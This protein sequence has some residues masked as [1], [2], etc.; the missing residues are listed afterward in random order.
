MEDATQHENVYSMRTDVS[1]GFY[2]DLIEEYNT[3]DSDPKYTTPDFLVDKCN[4]VRAVAVDAHG[5]KSEVVTASYFVGIAPEDYDGCGIVSVVTDPDNLFGYEDGIYVTGKTFDRYLESGIDLDSSYWRFWKANYRQTGSEWERTCSVTFFAPDGGL[6]QEQHIGAVRTHGGV[7][8]GTVPRSLNLY[9]RDTSDTEGC[10]EA[11]LFD[12][13]YSPDAVTLASGGNR[14]YTKFN[15]YMIF[16]RCSGLGYSNIKQKPYILFLDGE[17]WGFYWLSE[18]YDAGYLAY[19]YGVDPD[20][21]VMIKNG[22]VECGDVTYKALYLNMKRWITDYDLADSDN[23]KKACE[24]I[25]IDS[26]IDY[27]AT[28][29]YIA[30]QEDW[31]SS[32]F[33]LWRTVGDDGGGYSDGKWRWMMFDCNSTSMNSQ[34]LYDDSLGYIISNDELFASFWE[35]DVFRDAFKARLMGIADECFDS[36]EMERFIDGYDEAMRKILEKSWTRFHGTEN[37]IAQ[38]YESEMDGY[39]TFF[40]ERKAVVE[41]WFN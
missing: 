9:A 27:Y 20:N 24:M 5:N 21:V 38:R 31:P 32:N 36:G 18:K 12:N 8:R 37:D 19:Y 39:R 40:S 2:T 33:A 17:Y 11:G 10:F 4:I 15:D 6:I 14:L 23:Y 35:N 13:G 16:E 34:I 1:A 3:I 25:D 29:T 30:R 41:S 28:M 26:F 22:E 7:S